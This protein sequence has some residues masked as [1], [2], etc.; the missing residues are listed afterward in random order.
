MQEYRFILIQLAFRTIQHVLAEIQK[1]KSMSVFLLFY[2]LNRS[3]NLAQT[4]ASWFQIE[5]L[6]TQNDPNRVLAFLSAI[7]LKQLQKI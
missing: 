5:P 2:S 4:D 7:R 1:L 6:C 3:I